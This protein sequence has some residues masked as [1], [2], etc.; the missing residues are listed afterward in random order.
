MQALATNAAHVPYRNSKL[1]YL[2]QPCL[3]GTGKTL[4]FVNINPD[5]TS[6]Y[7]SLCSLRFAAK[8]NSVVTAAR[9]GAKRN[10][11]AV[12]AAGP[13]PTSSLD[14]PPRRAPVAP[15][16]L[17]AAAA[18]DAAVS[19]RQDNN[20]NAHPSSINSAPATSSTNLP[21]SGSGSSLPG[22][23][24][25]SLP[26]AASLPVPGQGMT[27]IKRPAPSSGSG[28]PSAKLARTTSLPMNVSQQR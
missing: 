7:E 21:L 10:N 17:R 14:P 24:A 11:N 6:A 13:A 26:S 15:K 20:E 2:L 9:G 25:S 5:P 4:M 19:M 3:G 28:L 16:P 27:G 1:T 23:P 12:A 18:Q 8:V 22:G